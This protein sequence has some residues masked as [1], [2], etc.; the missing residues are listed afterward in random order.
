MDQV[1]CNAAYYGNVA[2][3]SDALRQGGDIEEV[4]PKAGWRP[5]H[6]AVMTESEDALEYLLRQKANIDSPGPEGMT[7]LHIACRDESRDVLRILL[8]R[9][10]NV[11]VTDNSGRKP[12]ELCRS[13]TNRAK[14]IMEAF[15]AGAALPSE[16]ELLQEGDAPSLAEPPAPSPPPAPVYAQQD[17]NKGPGAMKWH[18]SWNMEMRPPA[19]V[20]SEDEG[21]AI[22]TPAPAAAPPS[23]PVPVLGP[24]GTPLIG[25]SDSYTFGS[26][27]NPDNEEEATMESYA[28]QVQPAPEGG[29]W[30]PGVCPGPGPGGSWAD[31]DY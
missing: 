9:K 28:A 19:F 26:A 13:T 14:R 8:Q 18:P 29:D 5:V 23:A 25:T 11:Q 31:Y 22:P 20:D 30:G 21:E 6:A 17:P 15:L 24:G 10:A 12:I 3:I 1:V 7:A 2:A 4:D 16:D 27:V